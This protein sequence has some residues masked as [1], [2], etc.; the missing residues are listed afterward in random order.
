MSKTA[1][2]AKLEESLLQEADKI[3]G[4]LNIARNRAVE[5]GLQ[6]WVA[7][8]SRELLA[9]EMRKAS[10]VTR[11]ESKASSKEWA[12]ALGDGLEKGK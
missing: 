2:S 8:K 10:L 6:M 1:I 7:Q 12:L 11:K 9:L 3:A 5:E 4:K